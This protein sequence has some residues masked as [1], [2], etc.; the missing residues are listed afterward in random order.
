MAIAPGKEKT[1]MV[2]VRGLP[3]D[4]IGPPLRLA[5]EHVLKFLLKGY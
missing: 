3:E 1:S 5:M 2:I 4:G